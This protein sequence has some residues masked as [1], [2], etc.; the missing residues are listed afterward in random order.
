MKQFPT[1]PMAQ[2][3]RYIEALCEDWR[4]AGTVTRITPKAD[5]VLE[6][7]R[8]VRGDAVPARAVAL[9]VEPSSTVSTAPPLPSLS[10]GEK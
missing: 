7:A 4:D 9:R 5:R 3:A 8:Q 2:H 6:I 1:N 10:Q